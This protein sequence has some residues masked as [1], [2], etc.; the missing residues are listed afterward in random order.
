M[1]KY[2]IAP[3]VFAADLGHLKD[4][5]DIL[6]E[7]KAELLHVD[8][9]DGH[10]VEKMAFGPDHIRSLRRMTGLP[11][12]VHLMVEKPE[13]ILDAVLDAGADIVTVHVESTNRLYSCI[14]KITKAGKK[15]GIV[16]TP[17][18]S[19]ETI[20][21][22]I[23]KNL[24][25]ILQMTINPGEGGQHFHPEILDKLRRIN[26]WIGEDDIDLEVDGGIDASNI[27]QTAEAGANVFV[28]G[29]YLFRGDIADNLETLRNELR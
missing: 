23:K 27:R 28:S 17:A 15:A 2:K 7:N 19:I 22:C 25:M 10:F 4:Q 8:V 21:P 26:D 14:E 9:M 12:D 3:S 20:D 18:T 24:S 6:E 11:L 29:G 13:R 1:R 5:L 16:L